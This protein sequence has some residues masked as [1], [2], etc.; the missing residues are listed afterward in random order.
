MVT[1]LLGTLAGMASSLVAYWV[2][3][4]SGSMQKN[5]AMER[6]FAQR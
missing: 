4:S 1:L 6:A 3:S 2:G 5:A